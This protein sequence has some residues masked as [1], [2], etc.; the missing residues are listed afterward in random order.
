VSIGHVTVTPFGNWSHDVFS[1]TP[2]NQFKLHLI[3]LQLFL[4]DIWLRKS[5]IKLFFLKTQWK[6]KVYTI[7]L[8]YEWNSHRLPKENILVIITLKNP[9]EKT[10]D[11]AY[12]LVDITSLKTLDEKILTRQNLY[13]ENSI[14]WWAKTG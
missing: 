6:N 13:K 8:D 12:N 10:N 11:E 14:I 9:L 2:P 7:L 4:Q 1:N 5:K 3:I